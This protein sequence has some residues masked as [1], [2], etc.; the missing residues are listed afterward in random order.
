MYQASRDG[1][2]EASEPWLVPRDPGMHKTPLAA[3]QFGKGT[4]LAVI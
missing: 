1:E 4:A 2:I 3:R